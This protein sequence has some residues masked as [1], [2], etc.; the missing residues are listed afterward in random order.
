[1]DSLCISNRVFLDKAY[2]FYVLMYIARF[3]N[4]AKLGNSKIVII[5]NRTVMAP[6]NCIIIQ[7]IKLITDSSILLQ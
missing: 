4:T 5:Q 2:I 6:S 3:K 1:M 7:H